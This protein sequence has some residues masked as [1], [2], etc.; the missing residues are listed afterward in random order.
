MKAPTSVPIEGI[1]AWLD[2]VNATL[3][4]AFNGRAAVR[5]LGRM[6]VP[7]S[8]HAEVICDVL[9]RVPINWYLFASHRRGAVEFDCGMPLLLCWVLS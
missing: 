9:P 4:S 3:D 6:V 1:R 5:V 2:E 8:F 7:P